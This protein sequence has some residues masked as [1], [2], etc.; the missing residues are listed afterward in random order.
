MDFLDS[1]LAKLALDASNVVS[2]LIG[3]RRPTM[4]SITLTTAVVA[5]ALAAGCS[6]VD[7]PDATDRSSVP[8]D[9]DAA[10][11]H[12]SSV[13]GDDVGDPEGSP[14]TNESVVRVV[15]TG[16][17]STPDFGQLDTVAGSGSAFIIDDSGLAVTNNHVVAG[18]ASIEVFF[19]DSDVPTPA[20]VV[21]RS[22][23]SDLAVI[24]LAGD[25][26][27]PAG[28]VDEPVEVGTEVRAAGFPLGDDGLI[29]TGGI[30]A[31]Q[32]DDGATPWASIESLIR[33]DAELQPGNSGG[34][35]FD[36]DAQVVGVNVAASDTGKYAIPA[37]VARPIIDT[38]ASGAD[39]DSVG[40]NVVA[41]R[42]D[43]TNESGVWVVSVEPGSPADRAGV[44]PG[45][46][47]TRAKGVRIG[48]DGT[49]ADY[50]AVLRSTGDG[51]L[52]IEIA[53]GDNF[54]AGSLGGQPLE[55]VLE[56]TGD[57]TATATQP[58]A[59]V[60]EPPAGVA[61]ESF[62]TVTDDTGTIA[63]DVPTEWS[64]RRTST[65]DFAG[66]Q[67]PAVSAS[68]DIGA[69]ETSIGSS[70]DQPGVAAI[71]F[72]ADVD[73]G[74]AFDVVTANAPWNS[75]CVPIEPEVFVDD[76]YVGVFQGFMD[77]VGTGSTVFSIALQRTGEPNWML[78]NVF[79]PTVAD[80][81]AALVIAATFEFTGTAPAASP[82]TNE[83]DSD[84]GTA[85]STVPA[86]D[87]AVEEGGATGEPSQGAPAPAPDSELPETIS[88]MDEMV[89]AIGPPPD[90]GEQRLISSDPE[91]VTVSYFSTATHDEVTAWISQRLDTFA[92]TDPYASEADGG[93]FRS[94]YTVCEYRNTAVD[95]SYSFLTMSDEGGGTDVE[96]QVV[97]WNA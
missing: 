45:D 62:E 60:T 90:A 15:T 91:A 52:P 87:G 58:P 24:D 10:P 16:T 80:L 69:L 77:C 88:S 34:P 25:G 86:D 68:F 96:I 66:A 11:V 75:D 22:E 36:N 27:L 76:A 3:L 50:C 33:H 40:L 26:Y 61:Y 89:T 38:L 65:V 17:F 55:P 20:T 63:V 72:S 30:V 13:G 85:P 92:C 73:I 97:D 79:A 49:L 8:P 51:E 2:D 29:L 6:S 32:D 14:A 46:V 41:I 1:V 23:C 12:A 84:T 57:V 56:F 64:D 47:I 19:D 95:M 28:W 83:P 67:R 54:L 9:R 44:Q 93:G 39:V 94:S 48:K 35:L 53:R 74:D 21:G 78:L 59:Q 71:V 70:Y 5:I 42:D 43:V 7:T 18:A 82:P 31:R 4:K 81:D 37:S